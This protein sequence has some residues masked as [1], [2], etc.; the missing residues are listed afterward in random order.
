[1]LKINL[2]NLNTTNSQIS[3][4][5]YLVLL[6]GGHVASKTFY[7]SIRDLI[8]EQIA[9]IRSDYVVKLEDFY[10]PEDWQQI[11]IEDRK[12]AGRCMA[13]LVI[14]HEIPLDFV[15]CKHSIPKE[16]RLKQS[17]EFKNECVMH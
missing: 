12:L 9:A 13:R 11:T 5:E 16:Y 17:T 10:D 2:D 15:G 8:L 6:S 4:P 7:D 1:M 3:T 14:Q